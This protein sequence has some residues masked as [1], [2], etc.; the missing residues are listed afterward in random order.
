MD[1]PICYVIEEKPLGTGGAVRFAFY[2][3]SDE[4]FLILNGDTYFPVDL[5]RFFKFHTE[6]HYRFTIALKRMKDFLRYG[7][8][9]CQGDT[10]IKFNE[11]K[12]C[13]EGLING[14]IYIVNR[15]FF[16]SRQLPD[17]FSLEKDILEKEAGS[18][19]LKCMIFDDRF[20]DIGIP[21]DYLRAASV[22][23]PERYK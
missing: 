10:V 5:N 16:E 9:E 14:G 19:L 1:I 3:T 11:K 2:E 6:N 15:E 20:I 22:L 17:S 12:F 7:N 8:V 23:T 18:S 4:N 21:D 13:P